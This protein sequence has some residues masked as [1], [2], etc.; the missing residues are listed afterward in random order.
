VR[1]LIRQRL[2]SGP[3]QPRLLTSDHTI[4]GFTPEPRPLVPAAVLVALIDHPREPTVLLTRRTEHLSRHAG[5]IS[6]PGGRVEASDVSPTAAALREAEEEIGLAQEAVDVLG[7]L[8]SYQTVTGFLITP[9]VGA[10]DPPVH[11]Q[12][13]PCEVAD[14]FEVPLSFILDT[15]NHQRHSRIFN[16]QRRYY[17]ALPYGNYYIWGAT[18][19]M[20]VNLAAKLN[21]VS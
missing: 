6:F 1:E 2:H 11:L 18:A 9:V 4:A 7:V 8:D 14:V 21:Y 15:A 20:L 12:P 13:D 10:L 19:A 3:R 5:Q 16:G 17:Y